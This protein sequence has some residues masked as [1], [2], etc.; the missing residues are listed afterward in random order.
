MQRPRAAT[1]APGRPYRSGE[2]GR[3]RTAPGRTRSG[4]AAAARLAGTAKGTAA[5]AQDAASCTGAA[6][7][8]TQ[9]RDHQ[10]HGPPRRPRRGSGIGSQWARR[11]RAGRREGQCRAPPQGWAGPGPGD[12][13]EGG[14]RIYSPSPGCGGAAVGRPGCDLGPSLTEAVSCAHAAALR[15]D[16]AAGGPS[17]PRARFLGAV[18]YGLTLRTPP[19]ALSNALGG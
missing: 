6:M 7:V 14:G 18:F 11:S 8:R 16:R 17:L 10:S 12:P 4:Q 9:R 15:S 13:M 3:G 5:G 19:E 2:G 1:G